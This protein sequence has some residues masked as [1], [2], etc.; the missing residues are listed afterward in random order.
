MIKKKG[1]SLIELV[2]VMGILGVLFTAVYM[3]FTKGTEQFHFARRQNELAT[4]GRLALEMIGNEV[5]WAGYMPEGGWTEDQWHP[6]EVGTETE[7]EF[8]ADMNPP[9][10]QLSDDDHRNITRG[11]DNI[12]RITDDGSMN[13]VAGTNI[14]ALQFNYFDTNGNLLAKPLNAIDRDAVRHIG[15]KITL[16][17]TY[18]G[19]VYQTVMQ[20]VITPRNLGVQH[21]FDPLFYLPPDTPGNIVVNVADSSGAQKPTLHETALINNLITW[22]HTVFI[23]VD[24]ELP[25]FNYDSTSIDL[26]ILRNIP[27]TGSHA[28]DSVSL[29]AIPIPV[30]AMDADDARLVYHMA[31]HSYEVTSASCPME[32]IIENHTINRNVPLNNPGS[33]AFSI[34]DNDHGPLTVTVLDSLNY[35]GTVDIVTA[36]TGTGTDSLSGVSVQN[37]YFPA[38]RRIHY[39][40]P[41][42]AYNSADGNVFLHD[43]IKWGFGSHGE[44]P[45]LGEE[46]FLETFEGNSPGEVE[47][48]IWE[49]NLENGVMLPDSI[50]LYTDF[51][52]GGGVGVAW[53]NTS[54]GSGE[55][56][57]PANNTLQ[58]HRTVTGGFDRN[59]AAAPF[60]LSAYSVIA[61][62]LYITV[63]TRKAELENITAE[64]GVFL[65]SSG[66]SIID[67][68]S[69][70][71]ENLILGNGDV[72]FWGDLH[73]RNRVH[74]P[75]WNNP[76]TFATLD[77]RVT[78]LARVRMIIEVD[79]ST[80]GDNTPI[81]VSYRMT[82][83][84]D[85]TNNY[86]SSDNSG[87]YIA[88]GT[89]WEIGDPVH[90]VSNFNPGSLT[91]GQWN[92]YQYTFT[93]SGS[94][95]PTV[96]VIFSRYGNDQAVSATQRDGISF[97]DIVIT[98]DNTTLNL[99][100]IG[101][102]P[103]LT[104]WQKISVDLDDQA[105]VY[106]VPFSSAFGIALSQY[107]QGPW[108]SANGHGIRWRNFE[109]GYID[110]YY[111]L[112]GWSHGPVTAGET[113][114]WLL[115]DIS[116]NHVWTL[117]NN[118][119]SYY[120]HNTNCWLAT[121]EFTIPA[122]ATEASLSILHQMNLEAGYDFGWIEVST[123]GG[124]T[125]QPFDTPSYTT[126]YN[127]HGAFSGTIPLSTL[128]LDLIA[129][130]GQTIRLRF[131]L[132]S[133]YSVSY[134]GWNLDNFV[135]TCTLQGLA[136]ETIGFKP[137]SPGGGWLFD[138]VDV[139]LGGVSSD[140]FTGNG[141]WDKN[142]LTFAG[143]YPVSA[144]ALDWVTID[145]NDVFLLPS[146][147]NLLVKLEMNQASPAAGFE[148]VAETCDDMSRWAT[149]ASVDPT[150]LTVADIKPAL[151]VT[152]QDY[153]NRYVYDA[154]SMTSTV[155]PLAFGSIYGDFEAIYTLEEL[156][157]DGQ[158]PWV[159]GGTNDDWEIG[160]P[161][162]TPDIDPALVP[163]NQNS[164]AGNDLTDDGRY[165]PNAWSWIRSGAYGMAEV[166]AYDSVAINY[167]RCLRRAGNDL[168]WVQLAFTYTVDPP[169]AESDWTNVKKCDYDDIP[170]ESDYINL[171]QYFNDARAAGKTHFFVRFVLSSGPFA[172][173]GGWNID[174]VGFYGRYAI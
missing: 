75:G 142:A 143:T 14:T 145:L 119:P 63:E 62:N 146:T 40:A 30:I 42:V 77:S 43:V 170:W 121:P 17:G 13:R 78:Q 109:L 132:H 74:S 144:S 93:P 8:Y 169:V 38:A 115:E 76:T 88:W 140:A 105:A 51:V 161:R 148:W 174:N 155:M 72:E 131:L 173:K 101:V 95:P 138:T 152:L 60:D 49:D 139:W 39:C 154:G 125:W 37:E 112:P 147:S 90:D 151:M 124:S 80:L 23:L 4:S 83:H 106:G 137:T 16:Q 2:I 113:D 46:I 6:I 21:N 7:L 99:D 123:N 58:M 92:N 87:D 24:D 57:R 52:N 126:S 149:S 117:H 135:A 171:T 36:F 94:M 96:Y 71:F 15:I 136:V 64:D 164:I 55:I 127:G 48:T 59:I 98:A 79:T 45:D 116:G 61:D 160:A 81:T 50:P 34:Y 100:R 102:P 110:T 153:G 20:T 41:C 118:N 91:N 120:S 157:F 89:G 22:G 68:V 70:N 27:G 85:E 1:M 18:M 111:S 129:H 11:I 133:D 156:G 5:R 166:A 25:V 168:A 107:G 103:D 97:D 159:H 32:K 67:L 108:Q 10:K 150:V 134:A 33:D 3:F 19:D 29:Q 165:E 122:G 54:T 69:E 47:L 66:G 104:G 114:D 31:R 82:D 65:I 44:N 130:T 84:N 86:Q 28:A 162:W 158:V 73:G 172:E 9:Y 56:T 53:V 35:G 12:V 163:G 167:D 26:V 128:N 141:E